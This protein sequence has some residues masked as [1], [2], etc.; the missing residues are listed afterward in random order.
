MLGEEGHVGCVIVRHAVHGGGEST[1][2]S[3]LCSLDRLGLYGHS[4]KRCGPGPAKSLHTISSNP[5]NV[6]AGSLIQQSSCIRG[7][8][9]LQSLEVEEC[10]KGH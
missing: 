6:V 10:C 7:E 8:M 9:H 5:I 4:M 2:E 1:G 3:Q